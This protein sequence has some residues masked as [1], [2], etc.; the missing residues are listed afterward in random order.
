MN[1]LETLLCCGLAAAKTI[2]KLPASSKWPQNSRVLQD[3]VVIRTSKKGLERIVV[4]D[5]VYSDISNQMMLGLFVTLFF[6]AIFAVN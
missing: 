3:I 5:Q 6:L 2:H 4:L 1:L